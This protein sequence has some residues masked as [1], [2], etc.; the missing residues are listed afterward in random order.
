MLKIMPL[1]SKSMLKKLPI[2]LVFKYVFHL[3]VSD[4]HLLV[5]RWHAYKTPQIL[6]SNNYG[7]LG[8][9]IVL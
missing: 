1:T 4:P 8:K 6:L 5:S 7:I 9:S 2:S 3:L